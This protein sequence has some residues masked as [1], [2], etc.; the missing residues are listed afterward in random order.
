MSSTDTNRHRAWQAGKLVFQGSRGRE[1]PAAPGISD[2][3]FE[4][5]VDVLAVAVAAFDPTRVAR[6]LKPDARMAQGPFAAVAGDAVGVHDPGFWRVLAHRGV[7][8]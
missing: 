4:I 8:G 1:A 6:D 2:F 7:L 5:L 3:A